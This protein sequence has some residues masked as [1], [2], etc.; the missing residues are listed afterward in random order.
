MAAPWSRA[1]QAIDDAR[2]SVQTGVTVAVVA[3]IL[4]VV[5]LAV[6]VVRR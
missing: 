3:L 2:G 5:A 6:A 4:A 1:R